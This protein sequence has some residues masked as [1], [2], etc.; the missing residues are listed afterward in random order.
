MSDTRRGLPLMKSQR[1]KI[2]PKLTPLQISRI[3]LHG[4]TRSVQLIGQNE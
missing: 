2:F 3:A 1:E 4:H